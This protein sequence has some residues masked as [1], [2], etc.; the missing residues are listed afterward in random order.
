M[1]NR[2]HYL[3]G[4]QGEGTGSVEGLRAAL[5]LARDLKTYLVAYPSERN[6]IVETLVKMAAHGNIQAI[7]EVFERIDGRVPDQHQFS[8][9]PVRIEFVPL[10]P[11][12][13]K[14]VSVIA[15]IDPK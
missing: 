5:S 14:P 9:L 12:A 11:S 10:M 3:P 13:Q 2:G 4:T 8:E 7:K 15:T 6:K 1:K